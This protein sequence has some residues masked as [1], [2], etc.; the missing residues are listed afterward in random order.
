MLIL[1]V[2]L[3]VHFAAVSVKNNWH[4]GLSRT[5]PMQLHSFIDASHLYLLN[6]CLL[7]ARQCM[8]KGYPKERKTDVTLDLMEIAY[9]PF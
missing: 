2:Y 6:V 8:G 7:S 4:V 3:T 9:W 1:E 5:S